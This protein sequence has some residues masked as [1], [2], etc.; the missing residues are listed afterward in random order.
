MEGLKPQIERALLGVMDP[1]MG[2]N[3]HEMGMVRDIRIDADGDVEVSIVFPC[4]GCPAYELIRQDIRSSISAIDGVSAV[5]VKVDW[6]ES[7]NKTD[8]AE[9]AVERAKIHGYVI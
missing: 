8:M 7:W 2:V 9:S 1:H 5:R 6:S 3:L 4:V